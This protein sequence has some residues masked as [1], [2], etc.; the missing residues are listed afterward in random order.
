MIIRQICGMATD[1]GPTF[2]AP[3]LLCAANQSVDVQPIIGAMQSV[4]NSL[5]RS[6]HR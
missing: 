1:L 4:K 6:N 2:D 3:S 5:N